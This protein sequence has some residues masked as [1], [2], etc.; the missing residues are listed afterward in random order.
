MIS[1]HYDLM[2]LFGA[3]SVNVVKLKDQENGENG[4]AGHR[5]II[6][7]KA[8]QTASRQMAACHDHDSVKGGTH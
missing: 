5:P 6:P 4:L 2:S 1:F 7:Q 3:F 8:V